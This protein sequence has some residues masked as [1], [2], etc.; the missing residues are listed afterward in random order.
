MLTDDIARKIGE[1]T[2]LY[3]RAPETTGDNR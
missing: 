3:G 2:V 1:L